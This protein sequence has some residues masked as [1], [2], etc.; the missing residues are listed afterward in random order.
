MLRKRRRMPQQQPLSQI[1]YILAAHRKCI[2]EKGRQKSSDT[3]LFLWSASCG[4]KGT[5][6]G[7]RRDIFPQWCVSSWPHCILGKCRCGRREG[8]VLRSSTHGNVINRVHWFDGGN[9]CHRRML[10]L[11]RCWARFPSSFHQPCLP[12][13]TQIGSLSLQQSAPR[14]GNT[15]F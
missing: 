10:L 4:Q 1:Y 5:W 6:K 9:N 3:Q 13:S 11:P 7:P 14:R 2:R 15:L 12:L 8:K